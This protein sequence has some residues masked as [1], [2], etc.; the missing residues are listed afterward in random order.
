MLR[1][2]TQVEA[3]PNKK[4]RR[5]KADLHLT[6][7]VSSRPKLR[8][9]SNIHNHYNPTSLSKEDRRDLKAHQIEV[10]RRRS[11]ALFNIRRNTI[12]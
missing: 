2:E 10:E 6:G 8:N 5:D 4:I 1:R 9:A 3:K 12:R 11:M 7:K